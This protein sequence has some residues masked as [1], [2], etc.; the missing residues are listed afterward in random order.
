MPTEAWPLDSPMFPPLVLRPPHGPRLVRL[1]VMLL[2]VLFYLPPA[3]WSPLTNGPEGEFAAAAQDLLIHGGWTATPT[4]SLH[5]PLVLWL[6]RLSLG[7]FG[8]NEFAA[9][10]PAVLS[11][12]ATVWVVLRMAERFGGIWQGFVAALVLLCSPGM[13]TLGRVLTPAPLTAALL[14]A[15]IYCLQRGSEC[16][17]TRRR[18]LLLAGIVWSLATLA[19]GWPA[20]I[21]PLATVLLLA[22]FYREARIR[23]RAL[24]SWQGALLFALTFT[25]LTVSGFPPLGHAEGENPW[26]RPL[27]LSWQAGLLFPWSLLLLPAFG[28]VAAQCLARRPLDWNE[29]LPFA[30]LVA[31]FAVAL[32]APS[33]F[34]PLLFWPAFA[35]W[36]AQRLQTMHRRLFL[37]GCGLIALVACGG[38]YLTQQ[39]RAVLPWLLPSKAQ[40]FAAIPDFF[41]SAVTPV[42]FIAVLAFLLFVGAAFWAEIF[43]NRRFALLALIAAMIPAGFAFADIGAKFASY[44]SDA[45][46]AGCIDSKHEAGRVIFLD[47]SRAETSSLRFY[48][49][50]ESRRSLQ[51]CGTVGDLQA[52]WTPPVLL[53]TSRSRLPYWKQLL[54]ARVSVVCESGEHVLLAAHGEMKNQETRKPGRGIE[55]Y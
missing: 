35:V 30:W 46:M 31:G 27:L 9:R 21:I 1:L 5:G 28:A 36:G 29:A 47:A 3:G 24:L 18:W 7:L 19:G 23:F 32:A 8:V 43:Q 12:V 25:V 48:L 53:V 50:E 44:F 39:L 42:A 14:A 26:A 37:W 34:S 38:L 55:M 54:E 2:A 4:A 51:P 41:W 45:A 17:P 22:L 16:R 52:A 33:L 6:A 49:G 10:L 15:T 40:A 11:V 13:F 20:G